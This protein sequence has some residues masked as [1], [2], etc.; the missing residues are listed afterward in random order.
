MQ[1]PEPGATGAKGLMTPRECRMVF[2]IGERDMR[3]FLNGGKL[4]FTAV[5]GRRMIAPADAVEC[6]KRWGRRCG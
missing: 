2:R 6:I 4:P 5:D 1:H 3:R